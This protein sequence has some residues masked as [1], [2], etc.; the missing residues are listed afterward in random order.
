MRPLVFA[1]VSDLPRPTRLLTTAV[2]VSA[3]YRPE[4]TDLLWI[5]V[6]RSV[7]QLDRRPNPNDSNG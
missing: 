5:P 2:R 3:T 1:C 4:P 6:G 7:D